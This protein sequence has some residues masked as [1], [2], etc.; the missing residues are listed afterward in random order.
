MVLNL[1]GSWACPKG[2][3]K[4]DPME[5][6]TLTLNCALSPPGV[7]R[8]PEPAQRSPKKIAPFLKK[9]MD[10]SQSFLPQASC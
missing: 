6:P 1:L 9:R 5:L 3:W 7:H 8:H 2:G 4:L 10:K